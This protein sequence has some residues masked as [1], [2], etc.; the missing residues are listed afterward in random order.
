[1]AGAVDDAVTMKVTIKNAA[2][3]GVTKREE[4]LIKALLSTRHSLTVISQLMPLDKEDPATDF[5][6]KMEE[7]DGRLEPIRAFAKFMFPDLEIEIVSMLGSP[8]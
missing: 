4:Q 1:M 6:K 2:E 3:Q 7:G 8:Q 5:A